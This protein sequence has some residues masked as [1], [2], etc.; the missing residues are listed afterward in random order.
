MNKIVMSYSMN[1]SLLNVYLRTIIG[2]ATSI[3]KRFETRLI[4]DK[5]RLFEGILSRS[6]VSFCAHRLKINIYHSKR[7]RK[8]HI[9]TY[10]LVIYGLNLNEHNLQRNWTFF[11]DHNSTSTFLFY[12]LMGIHRIVYI[13]S[14]LLYHSYCTSCNL[15][16]HGK[17]ENWYNTMKRNTCVRVVPFPNLVCPLYSL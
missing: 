16:Y 12:F 5:F 6:F 2:I 8:N 13:Q 4:I 1:C 14:R 10:Q 17:P 3:C 11:H 7:W 15:L 9:L